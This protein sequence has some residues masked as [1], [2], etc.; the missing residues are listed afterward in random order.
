MQLDVVQELAV[1]S[2]GRRSAG[3]RPLHRSNHFFYLRKTWSHMLLINL[4][5]LLGGHNTSIFH[6]MYI[7]YIVALNGHYS[8]VAGIKKLIA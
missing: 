3:R 4:W 6:E 5:R 2:P 1:D 7:G 8:N